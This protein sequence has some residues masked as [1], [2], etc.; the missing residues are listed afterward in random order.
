MLQFAKAPALFSRAG[1]V[2]FLLQISLF[3]FALKPF[4]Y[5]LWYQVEPMMLAVYVLSAL[6]ALWLSVGASR[7]WLVCLRP[8]HPLLLCMLAWVGWQCLATAFASLPLL[9]WFGTPSLGEGAAYHLAILLSFLV[10]SALWR[11]T[12]YQKII[13]ALAAFNLVVMVCLHIDFDAMCNP[14][15]YVMQEFVDVTAAGNWTE[16]L[17][18]PTAYLWIAF[19]AT[20]RVRTPARYVG[21]VLICATVITY[22]ADNEAARM[23]LRPVILWGGVLLLIHLIFRPR[24]LVPGKIWRTLGV[25]GCLLC[26][27]WLIISQQSEWLICPNRSLSTRALLNQVAVNA[28]ENNPMRLII[29]EGW[30]RFSDDLPKYALVDGVYAFK[31]GAIA[32]NWK[33]VQGNA[34]HVHNTPMEV[35]LSL[36]LPGLLLWLSLPMAVI[37]T[38]ARRKFWWAIPMLLG[39][40]TLQSFWFSLPLVMGFQVLSWVA[41]ASGWR[42]HIQSEQILVLRR[43][44]TYLGVLLAALMTWSA[45]EQLKGIQYG[46]RLSTAIKF[47]SAEGF[48][49]EWL[50]EDAKRGGV[51][52]VDSAL[53]HSGIVGEHVSTGELTQRDIEWY[54]LLAKTAHTLAMSPHATAHEVYLNM[55]MH[56]M[57]FMV[58]DDTAFRTIKPWAKQTMED[59]VMR[60]VKVVP[61]REDMIAAF[62]YSLE[63]FTAGDS[64]HATQILNTILAIAPNHRSAL[65]LM[66]QELM[67]NPA[68]QE[69][70]RAMIKRAVELGV[71]RVFPVTRE[72]L[73]AAQQLT[74]PAHY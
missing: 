36:G 45:T 24:W 39:I 27:V 49:E 57:V 48:S 52:F 65:W 68:T 25:L 16:Y 29:G 60:S 62:L 17:A 19:M 70:G 10:A 33:L 59:A 44:G 61:E 5:G 43:W 74:A 8:L 64:R 9:S 53:F 42:R 66:G 15:E 13:M 69:E 31:N 58:V 22:I 34:F 6:V 35:V 67:K 38:V 32:L 51:R 14:S 41:L 71:E 46:Q 37:I 63:G 4:H 26:F 1:L 50:L 47:G 40:T 56:N 21:I 3:V 72:E 55:F 28:F 18:F 54:Q 2:L 23:L 11:N 12:A 73:R 30:G 7:G 20:S